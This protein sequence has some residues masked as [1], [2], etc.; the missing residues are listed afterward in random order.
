MGWSR[1]EIRGHRSGRVHRLAPRGGAP[2]RGPRGARRRLASPTTTSARARSGTPPRSTC[3]KPISPSRRSSRFWPG[4][5]AS[6]T[7]PASR[8]CARAG[9]RASSSTSTGTCSRRSASSRRPLLRASGS[10]SPRPRP[11]TATPRPTRRRRTSSRSRSRRTGSR[12]SRASSSPS[13]SGERSGLDA[14][15]LRYFTVY[16]PRQRPDMAFT[17]MLEALARGERFRLFGDGSAAR[18]FTYVGDAVAATIAAM[19]RGRAGEIYNV[20]GG[21]EATMNE[22]IALARGDL[23]PHARRRAARGSRR[24]REAHEGGREQGRGRSGLGARDR[25]ARRAGGAMGMGLGRVARVSTP[26]DP[27]AEREVDLRSV[28]ERI[29]ARWWLPVL[30]VVLGA[31]DRLRARARRRQGL[32]GRDAGRDGPAVLAERR[33]ARREL[34]HERTRGRRDHPLRGRAREGR[35]GVRPARARAARQRHL[36]DRR[37]ERSRRPA[38]RRAA[39]DD[40]GRGGTAAQG[41]EGGRRARRGSDRADVGAVRRHEDQGVQRP[42]RIDPGSAEHARAADRP[43]RASRRTRPASPRSTSSSSSARWTTRSSG[44][45]SCSSSSRTSASSSRSPR[46]SR[47]R[48]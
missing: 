40:Q 29:A 2:R 25:A 22:A 19:E 5:T 44:A 46:T 38:D 17:A 36:P 1:S 47:R 34:H 31:R 43:A 33:R 48:R 16:G 14:V 23:G 24:R 21:D 18:S 6:S 28:W 42:A 7:S 35:E 41:G 3:S 8:A 12:S 26:A 11:S 4:P 45:A 39:G 20:G 10:S 13:R 32:R 27:D 15:V 9:A 37:R 30:G